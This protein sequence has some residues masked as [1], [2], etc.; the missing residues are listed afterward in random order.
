MPTNRTEQKLKC[1][2]CH[3]NILKGEDYS[4]VVLEGVEMG[5]ECSSCSDV[6]YEWAEE[7]DLDDDFQNK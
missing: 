1:C 5:V 3:D 2:I 7:D 6:Y 4:P